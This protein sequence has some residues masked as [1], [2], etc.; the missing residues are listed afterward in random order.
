MNNS[1]IRDSQDVETTS[2][3]KKVAV[4]AG[5]G[6]GPEVV[7]QGVRILTAAAKLEDLEIR[8]TECMIGEA[9][10]NA[11]GK[12]L[13]DATLE[14]CKQSDA[15]LFGA[16]S[17]HGLLELRQ[18]CN[19]FANLRP[20]N[21]WGELINKSSLRPEVAEG[22][23][24]LFV[25]ELVGGIYFGPSGTEPSSHRP[26]S[27]HT[28]KYYDDQIQQVARVAFAQARKR[29]QSVVLA[30]KE[31][32]LPKIRWCELTKEISQDYNDVSL[33]P[34]L[35][36]TVA[37]ELVRQPNQFDV[38]LAGNLFGD[39]LSDIGAGIVGSIGLLPSASL[40]ENEQGMY[41]A[42]HGTAPELANTDTVNPIAT[43]LSVAMMFEV[44]G[45]SN[46][47]K[48][49]EKAVRQAV[50]DGYR[51]VDIADGKT[52]CSTRD[53]TSAV[54]ERMSSELVAV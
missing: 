49:I 53:F 36:D 13:P 17:K 20:V 29:R 19:F 43:L 41:E 27:Y 9:A 33:T 15:V 12:G 30:H 34:M 8:T 46:T 21:M 50:A 40:N 47:A 7:E 14:V 6:V 42:I 26:Y 23:D 18:G 22:C 24:I 52:G 4:L 10:F 25:R 54:L 2:S 48:N 35:V 45:H 32:A 1:P 37:M 3:H 51:T 39:I 16:V 5:E 44:W 31:N 38:I 11:N 28:M